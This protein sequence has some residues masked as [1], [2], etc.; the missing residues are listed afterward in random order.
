MEFFLLYTVRYW[1]KNQESGSVFGTGCL[2][3]QDIIVWVKMLP[4]RILAG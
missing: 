2:I 3:N 4:E 1:F